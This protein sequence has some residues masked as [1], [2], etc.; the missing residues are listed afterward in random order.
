SCQLLVVNTHADWDHCWGNQ[1]FVGQTAIHPAPIIATRRCSERLHEGQAALTL[2]EKQ[3]E[4]PGVY[5]EVIPTPPTILF[6]DNLIIDGGDLTLHL[7]ATPGHES[8][9]C[10]IYIPE[11]KTLFPGDAAEFPFP[12][13][14][15]VSALPQMRASLAKLAELKA[16]V[17]LYCHAPVTADPTL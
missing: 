17:A 2:R 1:L 15:S 8:D 9:H 3:G 7:F 6:K 13:A 12:F 5:D 4:E 14:M 16:E 11:I 10:S